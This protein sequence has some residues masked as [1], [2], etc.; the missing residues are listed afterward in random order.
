[1]I[2]VSHLS[3]MGIYDVK[4]GGVDMKARVINDGKLL[5][6]ALGEL[7]CDGAHPIVGLDVKECSNFLGRRRCALFI[8]S[9]RSKCLIIQLNVMRRKNRSI[10]E[11]LTDF[12]RDQS[13]CFVCPNGFLKRVRGLSF[14]HE[15][16]SI[17]LGFRCFRCFAGRFSVY[18]NYFKC[19][20]IG[21]VEVG[22]Y[23][24]GV[25]KNPELLKCKSLEKLGREAQVDL[26]SSGGNSRRPKWDSEVF[27]PEEVRFSPLAAVHVYNSTTTMIPYILQQSATYDVNDYAVI[28]FEWT[29]VKFFEAGRQCGDAARGMVV[30]SPVMLARGMVVAV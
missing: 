24:A 14:R 2:P 27:S 19:E 9:T 29:V 15:G 10:P 26:T 22:Q 8:L 16:S 6:A 18:P 17:R 5:S 1:M 3:K 20:E 21:G 12:L 28:E 30:D 7:E 13:V 4:I 11:A 25:L 23:A